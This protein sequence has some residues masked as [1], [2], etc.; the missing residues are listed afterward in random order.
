[1]NEPSVKEG[2][3]YEQQKTPKNTLDMWFG[4]N[5]IN[6]FWIRTRMLCV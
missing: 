5:V 2:I 4:F 1:M 6:H 3:E